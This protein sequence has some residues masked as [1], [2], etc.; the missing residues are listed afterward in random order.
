[1]GLNPGRTVEELRELQ[2]VTGDENGAQRVA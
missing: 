1:M 2:E